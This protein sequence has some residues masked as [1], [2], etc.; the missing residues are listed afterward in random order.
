MRAQFQLKNIR[1]LEF[2][3]WRLRRNRVNIEMANLVLVLEDDH[4]YLFF[5][6]EIR[7]ER[8]AEGE[9]QLLGER[10]ASSFRVT[11]IRYR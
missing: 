2:K 8:L 10:R 7:S 4:N 1:E 9:L 6:E 3:E 11:H 5:L